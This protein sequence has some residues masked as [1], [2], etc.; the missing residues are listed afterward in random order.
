LH[1]QEGG[2]ECVPG[3]HKEFQIWAENRVVDQ[4]GKEP[5]PRIISPEQLCVGQFTAIRTKEEASTIERF[6]HIPYKAGDIVCWDYRIPHANSSENTTAFP[7]EVLY[8]GMLPAIE[9]NQEFA[10]DQLN[11]FLEG[12]LPV[13]F[14][15]KADMRQPCSY[16]FSELGRKL[17]TIDSWQ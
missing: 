17:M 15:H 1:P 4:G 12:I 16:E 10:K 14:W 7:R 6:Q 3:F 2:F 13:G 11:R 8:L 5:S 9:K